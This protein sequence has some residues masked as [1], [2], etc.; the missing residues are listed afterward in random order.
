MTS[1]VGRLSGSLRHRR[2]ALIFYLGMVAITGL[3]IVTGWVALSSFQKS[4]ETLNLTVRTMPFVATA[5]R[6]AN[7]SETL[8]A[9]G[10]FLVTAES[11]PTRVTARIHLDDQIQLLRTQLGQFSGMVASSPDLN[12]RVGD[13]Q[14]RVDQLGTIVAEMDGAVEQ[15]LKVKKQIRQSV[16]SALSLIDRIVRMNTDK[17]A[18]ATVVQNWQALLIQALSLAA[19]DS[20]DLLDLGRKRR[21]VDTLLAQALDLEARHAMGNPT[22]IQALHDHVVQTVIGEAGIFSSRGQAFRLERSITGKLLLAQTISRQINAG[23]NGVVEILGRTSASS[24]EKAAATL[25]SSG[26]ILLWTVGG[27][28]LTAILY[29]LVIQRLVFRRLLK[30]QRNMNRHVLGDAPEIRES[31]DDEIHQ[32]ADAFKVF[33]NKRRL[34]E[35]EMQDAREQAVQANQSKTR[36]L[37]AASHDLRQP[38]QAATLFVGGLVQSETDPSRRNTLDLLNQSIQ[39]LRDLLD[40]ILEIARLDSGSI[41]P[42]ISTVDLA[43]LLRRLSTEFEVLAGR[44]G[45]SFTAELEDA[46]V[47]TDAHLLER[48]TRNLIDNAM[49]YTHKGGIHLKLTR[50]GD[51]VILEVRD[52]G[53]GI[54]YAEQQ[55]IFNEFHQIGNESRDRGRGLGLGLSIVR[56]LCG[57]LH[58][59][60]EL[61]SKLGEGSCFRLRLRS[62]RGAVPA[63]LVSDH[64]PEGA[65]KGYRVLVVDDDNQV[66][67]ATRM[68]LQS[69]GMEV[70]G[71]DN[72]QQGSA[73]YRAMING[74][75]E[76]PHLIIADYRLP[77]GIN[78][79][80]VIEVLRSHYNASIPAVLITGEAQLDLSKDGSDFSGPILQK[81]VDPIHLQKIIS[82]MLL[83]EAPVP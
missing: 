11:Q 10:I 6:L 15:H 35:A 45:L 46:L 3:T 1:V 79:L 78:G 62:T 64:V 60:L 76:T 43:L 44:K 66:L 80:T 27:A 39:T 37:A 4:R 21:E 25:T 24:S 9:Q 52:T 48:I 20:E 12:R 29:F 61:E 16:D 49:K 53:E 73:E 14:Q 65:L 19:S 42:A 30:L 56:Q 77:H 38:L 59:P 31:G 69:W 51:D 32:M 18:R 23:A 17:P 8:E 63:S 83:V 68:L 50:E 75:L 41:T 33:V 36:F 22:D 28:I 40:S 70:H 34:A 2:V 7:M 13:L 57:L 71:S 81:P 82:N 72:P 74:C 5:S 47:T 67:Q 54:P 58:I 55:A 26:K